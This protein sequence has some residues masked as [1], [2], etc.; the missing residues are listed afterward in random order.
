MADRRGLLAIMVVL[1]VAATWPVG[2]PPSG[3]LEPRAS[4]KSPLV[5]R[6]AMPNADFS[7]SLSPPPSPSPSPSP[8]G[9]PSAAPSSPPKAVAVAGSGQVD[10]AR[11][12]G[13]L[14]PGGSLKFTGSDAV[15]LT[16]D[17]GP[18]PVNTPKI[19]DSLHQ[20]GVKATFC[21]VGFRVRD[22]PDLVRRIAAEGHTLCNHSWQHLFDL[23][24]RGPGYIRSDLQQT[25]DAIHAAA[26]GTPISYFRAP[27]GNFTAGLVGIARELGMTSIYW[28]VDPRDWESAKHGTGPAMV[29]HIIS[30][31]NSQT[32]NGSIVLSHD[33]G[34]PDTIEAYRRLFPQLKARFNLVTL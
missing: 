17:D 7:A 9:T 27:G 19:L 8:A 1:V 26:P 21:L 10:S 20:N 16:F 13:G 32:R 31:V 2:P 30:V 5:A 15:A 29:D 33:N 25:N 12:A 14:G 34:K 6:S 23:A 22:H 28:D 11:P 24:K 4:W 18:D 3:G